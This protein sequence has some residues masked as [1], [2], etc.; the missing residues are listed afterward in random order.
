M[1]QS[2]FR[3]LA[4]VQF[5]VSSGAFVAIPV[6]N[7]VEGFFLPTFLY[8]PSLKFC[9][10]PRLLETSAGSL[11]NL[12]MSEVRKYHHKHKCRKSGKSL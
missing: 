5:K 9:H 8:D 3:C 2:L 12:K 7:C 11:T 4:A 6:E 1:V 10:F